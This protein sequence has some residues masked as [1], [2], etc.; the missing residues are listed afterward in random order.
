MQTAVW[1]FYIT[2]RW[3]I[4]T[5]ADVTGS[6]SRRRLARLG[7][8]VRL[9]RQFSLV[10]LADLVGFSGARSPSLMK[11]VALRRPGEENGE[12]RREWRICVTF[13]NGFG[14]Q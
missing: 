7:L 3:R 13:S 10:A 6:G 1:I 8:A 9:I 4:P 2:L 5:L 11:I 14:A 12:R